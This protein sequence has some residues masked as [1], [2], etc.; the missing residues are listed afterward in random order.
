MEQ[1]QLEEPSHSSSSSS[2][3]T[4]SKGDVCTWGQ[5]VRQ[6][7][8]AG[9]AWSPAPTAGREPV[10]EARGGKQVVTNLMVIMRPMLL[11]L[12]LITVNTTPVTP[13]ENA[14]NSKGLDELESPT[15]MHNS[16]EVT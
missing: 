10:A 6:Y 9:A 5:G 13:I 4:R 7:K 2:N 15:D 14:Y 3:T 8:H 12:A 16:N 1:Q 11:S